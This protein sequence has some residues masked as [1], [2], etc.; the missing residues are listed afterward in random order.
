MPGQG[1]T[2][3]QLAERLGV[4]FATVNR[5]GSGVP[6]PGAQRWR[7]RQPSSASF[8]G[9]GTTVKPLVV[10]CLVVEHVREP[11]EE[12]QSLRLAK[13]ANP[14]GVT[15]ALA[16]EWHSRSGDSFDDHRRAPGVLH[17]RR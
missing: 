7:Q 13:S 10:V 3:E 4:S 9:R 15:F 14:C 11:L 6:S 17:L 5:W 1:L 2:Q 12:Q 16:H 8:Q